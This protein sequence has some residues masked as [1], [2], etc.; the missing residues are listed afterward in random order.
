MAKSSYLLWFDAARGI[1]A[2]CVLAG[3][4]YQ[5]F[6]SR[7]EGIELICAV[8]GTA[9]TYAVYIFFAMSGYLI[10]LSITN[11]IRRNSRFV[12]LDSSCLGSSGSIRPSLVQSQSQS[13]SWSWSEW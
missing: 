1:A 8:L 13:Q 7:S 3:H 6:Y 9:A 5:V 11:N 2:M 12:A 10:T 4:G